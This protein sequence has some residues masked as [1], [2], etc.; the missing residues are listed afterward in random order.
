MLTALI[1]GWT[2]AYVDADEVG[3]LVGAALVDLMH[4]AAHLVALARAHHLDDARAEVGEQ[5]RAVRTGEHAREVEDGEA[6][7][8]VRVAVHSE[9]IGL[10]LASSKGSSDGARHRRPTAVD[11]SP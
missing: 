2:G 1:D 11:P 8:Q 10:A 9:R 5:P 6:G 7:E 3:A 4:A